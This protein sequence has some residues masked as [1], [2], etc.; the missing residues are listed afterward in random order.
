VTWG[1]SLLVQARQTPHDSFTTITYAHQNLWSLMV[2]VLLSA[3]TL[4]AV[5]ASAARRSWRIVSSTL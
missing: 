1:V 3:V 5:S 2:L 4:S